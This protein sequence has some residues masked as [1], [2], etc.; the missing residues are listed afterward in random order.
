MRTSVG[1]DGRTDERTDGRTDVLAV[2]HYTAPAVD[3]GSSEERNAFW[4]KQAGLRE[5]GWEEWM[6]G[7]GW[8][9][10]F[11]PFQVLW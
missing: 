7:W 1:M 4:E 8:G 10:T 5:K 6:A 2:I 3:Y 11:T 9:C